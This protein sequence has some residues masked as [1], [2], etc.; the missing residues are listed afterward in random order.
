M[1]HRPIRARYGDEPQD[2]DIEARGSNLPPP[3]NMT[4]KRE[5]VIAPRSIEEEIVPGIAFDHE[6]KASKDVAAPLV[7]R[8][9]VGH[10]PMETQRVE[11]VAKGG[12][13]RFVHETAPDVSSIEAIAKVARLERSPHEGSEPALANDGAVERAALEKHQT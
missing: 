2:D 3:S 10:D 6:S 1:L 13:E 9:V 12:C 5:D 11:R 4:W 8:A 7:G